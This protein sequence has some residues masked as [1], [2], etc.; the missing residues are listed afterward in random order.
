MITNKRALN[1]KTL[2]IWV[3]LT[4]SL[5]SIMSSVESATLLAVDVTNPSSFYISQGDTF[6][7]TV[8]LDRLPANG[9]CVVQIDL[10]WDR[11]IFDYVSS[12]TTGTIALTPLAD[13]GMTSLTTGDR[14]FTMYYID[15]SSTGTSHLKLPG[16]LFTIIL[17]VKSTES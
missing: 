5:F 14:N 4:L 9:I 7:V 11:N 8:S 16:A 10:S 2:A 6:P 12:N 1:I 15:S 3:M 17:K 13:I